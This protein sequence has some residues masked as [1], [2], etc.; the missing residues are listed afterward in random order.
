[1]SDEPASW[2]HADALD[3]ERWG[4]LVEPGLERL[5]QARDRDRFPQSVLLVGPAGLGRSP[6]R[7]AS[8]GD[9][10]G[11]AASSRLLKPLSC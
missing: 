4:P 10:R 2:W 7:R 5:I 1:M 8:G 6:V 9:R 3:R 11:S